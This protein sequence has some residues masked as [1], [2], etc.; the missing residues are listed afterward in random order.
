VLV[1]LRRD[2]QPAADVE[3]FS[4]V[5]YR[6]TEE[7]WPATG[8]VRTDAAGAA[9]ITFNVG[10]ATPGYPVEVHVFAQLD[11]Q[12]LSWTTTFTPR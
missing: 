10:A 4:T 5:Q 9:S 8:T 3:V 7:R 2:G 6:T 11:G 12:Q 1:R